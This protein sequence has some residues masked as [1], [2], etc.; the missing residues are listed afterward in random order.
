MNPNETAVE[1]VGCFLEWYAEK[2]MK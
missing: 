1:F 2:E